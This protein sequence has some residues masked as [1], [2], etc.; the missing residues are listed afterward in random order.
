MKDGRKGKF[1]KSV[2]E[3]RQTGWNCVRNKERLKR[4]NKRLKERRKKGIRGSK[5][6]SLSAG[7]VLES[8]ALFEDR[9]GKLPVDSVHVR[10]LPRP[11][12]LQETDVAAVTG[13]EHGQVGILLHRLHWNGCRR[14]HA[15]Q[16]PALIFADGIVVALHVMVS[17]ASM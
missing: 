11:Q 8:A 4:K 10:A 1:G 5:R 2:K 12:A 6:S 17:A 13:N 16:V 9:L 15:T 7:E 14:K 3:G